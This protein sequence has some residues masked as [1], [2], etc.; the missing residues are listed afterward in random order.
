M[1][2]TLY[3]LDK[4]PRIACP[5]P[6]S[7]AGNPSQTQILGPPP[8]PWLACDLLTSEACVAQWCHSGGCCLF[9]FQ[10]FD[11]GLYLITDRW[12]RDFFFGS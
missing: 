3:S 7:R 4:A 12:A 5:E 2:T 8:L 1:E 6:G 9:W 11:T 10:I